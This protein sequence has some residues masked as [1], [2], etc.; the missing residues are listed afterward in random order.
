M[1]QLR[2]THPGGDADSFTAH[3]GTE[4]GIYTTQ[5]GLG[6][7]QCVYTAEADIPAG[8]YYALT[9][10]NT[11]GTSEYSNVLVPEP[12]SAL[13]FGVALLWW[14]AKGRE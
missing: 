5:V 12:A 14:L 6:L 9:A 3:L 2:W 10:T 7:P 13:L 11:E 4:P 1:T 8:T